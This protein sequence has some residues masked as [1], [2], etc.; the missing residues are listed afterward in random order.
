MSDFDKYS[1]EGAY[2]WVQVNPRHSRFN[3]PLL[4]RYQMVMRHI[5]H[6]VGRALDI[7]CGD[8]YLT[9]LLRQKA[10]QVVGLDPTVLGVQL[11]KQEIEK[12]GQFSIHLLAASAYEL[13]FETASF[14]L[15]ISTD[16]IEHVDRPEQLASEM[17][18]IL[19]P[20]GT[21]I[22]TTPNWSPTRPISRH[23]V[24]EFKPEQ[25]MAVLDPYFSH[26]ELIAC[27]PSRFMTIWKRRGRRSQ[28][29][30]RLAGYG[31]NVFTFSTRQIT[32]HYEQLVAVCR[33]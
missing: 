2:H 11:A 13:P 26:V 10:K 6:T 21:A 15:A 32:P 33:R 12:Q 1:I 27:W 19:Q 22:I 3:P 28:L 31:L 14:E 20:K 17:S 30:S 25:L 18:R 9:Y 4:A 24:Q 29:I 8:G 5:P 23:H 7:G 16:V